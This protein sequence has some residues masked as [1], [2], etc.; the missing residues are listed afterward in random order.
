MKKGHNH[1]V[2]MGVALKIPVWRH[3]QFLAGIDKGF[4]RHKLHPGAIDLSHFPTPPPPPPSM[5]LE[6]IA[7]EQAPLTLTLGLQY[8]FKR[9]KQIA[10][11]LSAAWL[12]TIAAPPVVRYDWENPTTHE[13]TAIY[14]TQHGLEFL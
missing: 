9:W 5:I 3:F 2:S 8:Q 11:Y 4:S 10:P 13:Q 12:G 6:G 7:I 1:T 14:S